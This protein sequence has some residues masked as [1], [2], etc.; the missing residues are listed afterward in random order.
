M[1]ATV[2][3]TIAAHPD[4]LLKTMV[5][6]EL[7]LTGEHAEGSPFQGALVMGASFGLGALV[8]ILVYLVPPDRGRDLGGRDRKRR[9]AV[10]DR[11]A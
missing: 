4:V 2:A 11:G 9:R 6:K 1:A 8:P 5:E 10:R 3:G 7:G